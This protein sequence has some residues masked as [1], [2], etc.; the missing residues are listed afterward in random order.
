MSSCPCT[1][2]CDWNLQNGGS[3][4]FKCPEGGDGRPL[5]AREEMGNTLSRFGALYF[6]TLLDHGGFPIAE[7]SGPSGRYP[8]QW[9]LPEWRRLLPRDDVCVVDFPMCAFGLRAIDV[10]GFYL[11][12]TRVVFPRH[13]QLAA[14]LARQC[15]GVSAEHRHIPL[16]GARPGQLVT[17]CTE[18]GVYCP[19][20][21]NTV[22][23][24]LTSSLRG[25]SGFRQGLRQRERL[26][27]RLQL[28]PE[29]GV[30]RAPRRQQLEVRRA[31]NWQ[32][33]E[34]GQRLQVRRRL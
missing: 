3:R 2:Y 8:K 27:A 4:S 33:T 6:E 5:T 22:V 26:R 18:A 9:D 29:P 1:S 14:A 23:E 12:K 30:R 15:P 24:V 28:R 17:R 21:V 34:A 10:D 16:K 7:S 13:P 19:D 31:Q 20:F 11:H 25:G 32:R